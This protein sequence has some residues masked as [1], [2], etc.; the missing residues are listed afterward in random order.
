MGARLSWCL[1]VSALR[2]ACFPPLPPLLRSVLARPHHPASSSSFFPDFSV[3]GTAPARNFKEGTLASSSPPI[4]SVVPFLSLPA[5]RRSAFCR[6]GWVAGVWFAQLS[7]VWW[8]SR[9][10]DGV[11]WGGGVTT[12]SSLTSQPHQRARIIHQPATNRK[13]QNLTISPP[14]RQSRMRQFQ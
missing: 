1:V 6:T 4:C 8:T 3:E 12:R 10:M 5:T 13:P 2:H 14:L 7:L 11:G 9:P